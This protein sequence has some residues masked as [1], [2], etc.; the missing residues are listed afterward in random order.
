MTKLK[1]KLYNQIY[2]LERRRGGKRMSIPSRNLGSD[3]SKIPTYQPSQSPQSTAPIKLPP[4]TPKV[5]T[6]SQAALHNL[7]SDSQQPSHVKLTAGTSQPH[8]EEFND[9]LDVFDIEI[10]HTKKIQNQNSIK[11]EKSKEEI[12]TLGVKR[13]DDKVSSISIENLYYPKEHSDGYL[14]FEALAHAKLS[15][16]NK[17]DKK[18]IVQLINDEVKAHPENPMF[19]P[20]KKA[21][22]VV[23]SPSGSNI[24]KFVT[25]TYFSDNEIKK[26]NDVISKYIN[27]RKEPERSK[28]DRTK[29]NP[30][31]PTKEREE[32]SLESTKFVTIIN[33]EHQNDTNKTT[34]LAEIEFLKQEQELKK[35]RAEKKEEIYL[36]KLKSD[37]NED[38]RKQEIK[39]QKM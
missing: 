1:I 20:G 16:L 14:I 9:D 19:Q 25:V 27:E 37:I 2:N 11:I 36:G 23:K 26:L 33:S 30:N 17:M 31:P 34:F 18:K 13:I 7:H 29:V 12:S 15:K 10:D 24:H 39:K 28:T 4:N 38:I 8:E 5:N 35:E 32:L 3:P 21:H 22:V 6:A